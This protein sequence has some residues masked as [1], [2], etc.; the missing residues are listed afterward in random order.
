MY[1]FNQPLSLAGCDTRSVFKQSKAGLN[2][3]FFHLDWL[4]NQG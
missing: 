3:V 4:S 2:S 1:I